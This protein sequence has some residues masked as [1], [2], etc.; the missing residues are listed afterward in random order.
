VLD[1]F[2]WRRMETRTVFLPRRTVR[3]LRVE[4]MASLA[5]DADAAAR[6]GPTP[7]VSEGDVLTAWM[8][9]M[10]AS[11]LPLSSSRTVGISS[12]FGFRGRLTS[13]FLA[14]EG[15]GANV[16]NAV[17]PFF[18]N[19]PASD[20]IAR[21]NA[22]EF[23]ARPIRRNIETQATEAQI[24]AFARLARVSLVETELL[25]FF[26]DTSFFLVNCSDWTKVRFF[27]VLDFG[28]AVLSRRSANSNA[29]LSHSW[30]NPVYYHVQGVSPND[31]LARNSFF[32]VGT[33]N[34]DYWITGCFPP[35][36]W[37]K[38]EVAVSAT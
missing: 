24:R 18:T 32:L 37:R 33:P 10:A 38:V 15:E 30:Y 9:S 27:E 3:D 22:L 12:A 17:L 4:A 36:V 20:L 23:A 35:E 6:D 13:M 16:Q 26:G 1:M 2:W 5:A 31:M 19:P 25:P 29:A 11:V 7:F 28:P 8:I 14:R 21:D 34:G